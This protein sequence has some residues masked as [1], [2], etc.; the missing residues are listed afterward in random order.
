M[1]AFTFIMEIMF[2]ISIL[3]IHFFLNRIINNGFK[4]FYSTWD[5]Y[6][7]HTYTLQVIELFHFI[8]QITG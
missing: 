4:I 1:L 2:R 8:K 3:C 7:C 5:M 6:T